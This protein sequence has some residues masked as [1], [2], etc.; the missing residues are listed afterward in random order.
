MVLL[1]CL[2][3]EVL[4]SSLHCK[5]YCPL[6][7]LWWKSTFRK[8]SEN[9]KDDGMSHKYFYLSVGHVD[10]INVSVTILITTHI[11]TG[12]FIL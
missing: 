11:N 5:S 2:E 6:Q 1:V 7:R 3:V 10:Q 12:F 4:S 9:G 8:A